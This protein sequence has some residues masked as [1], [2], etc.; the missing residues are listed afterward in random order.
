MAELVTQR[1]STC[2][3]RSDV[4]GF[5]R[6]EWSGFRSRDAWVCEGCLPFRPDRSDEHALAGFAT[7]LVLTAFF[8]GAYVYS[9]GTIPEG[10]ALVAGAGLSLRFNILIHEL[11]HALAA[12]ALG[13]PVPIIR[14]GGGPTV[15]SSA[16]LG[17][18]F[19][20]RRHAF[21]GGEVHHMSGGRLTTALIALAGPLSNLLLAVLF[22][23]LP[24]LIDTTGD[25]H[26]LAAACLGAVVSNVLLGLG[27]LRPFQVV[28]KDGTRGYSDGGWIL[29]C[30]RPRPRPSKDEK[31]AWRAARLV[32]SGRRREGL[33]LY[34][35]L[36][37][38]HP[39]DACLINTLLHETDLEHGPDAALERYARLPNT[40]ALE[41]DLDPLLRANLVW[42][43]LKAGGEARLRQAERLAPLDL[44]AAF[45]V[46]PA[47]QG[48]LEVRRG[49]PEIGEPLLLRALRDE[50]VPP[51][52][53]A[54]LCAFLAEGRRMRGNEAT[55]GAFEALARRLL[56]GDP[57][58][59]RPAPKS[60]LSV[61]RLEP[62]AQAPDLR[63]QGRP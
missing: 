18:R 17:A 52:D 6:E 55:A 62:A 14:V 30:L 58:T 26:A 10:L 49:A 44:D 59:K 2:G 54:A 39:D 15:W 47:T 16:L 8:A 50:T 36:L 35:T 31:L 21:L 5:F 42:M 13:A 41:A 60:G 48:A 43:A 45:V 23:A 63:R 38:S 27:N 24:A 22:G 1:C 20:W 25:D 32:R 29:D 7:G 57:T 3:F 56:D 40:E 37:A 11:A 12:R 53:R 4:E 33:A 61:E 34:E 51:T 28:H 9:F 19:E 46:I